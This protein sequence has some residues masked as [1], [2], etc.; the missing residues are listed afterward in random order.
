MPQEQLPRAP[1]S[2]PPAPPPPP[3]AP[4]PPPPPPPQLTLVDVFGTDATGGVYGSERGL[5]CRTFNTFTSLANATHVALALNGT[6][7]TVFVNG[8]SVLRVGEAIDS[9]LRF[10]GLLEDPGGS[11]AWAWDPGYKLQLGSDG[12]VGLGGYNHNPFA[13]PVWLAAVYGRP[14]TGSEVA[15]NFAAALPD[16]LPACVDGTTTILEDGEAVAG[17]AVATPK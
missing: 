5:G 12:A 15:A 16:S 10:G 2:P 1:P 14:L 9:S 7:A 11:G 13:A 4:P 6:A 3:P 8:A 17:A